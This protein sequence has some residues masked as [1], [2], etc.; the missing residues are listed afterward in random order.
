MDLCVVNGHRNVF[1]GRF[2]DFRGPVCV[3]GLVTLFSFL[4]ELLE[5]RKRDKVLNVRQLCVV[6]VRFRCLSKRKLGRDSSLT[7]RGPINSVPQILDPS[8]HPIEVAIPLNE[9]KHTT[10]PTMANALSYQAMVNL[11]HKTDDEHFDRQLDYPAL[12]QT[13][14][15]G[16]EHTFATLVARL[17]KPGVEDG[18]GGRPKGGKSRTA[19]PMNS[20]L[21]AALKA[22][23]SVSPT[24]MASPATASP[25]RSPLGAVAEARSANSAAA[26][27]LQGWGAEG[28]NK[29]AV[30]RSRGDSDP[31]AMSRMDRMTDSPTASPLGALRSGTAGKAP[32]SAA[33]AA[34]VMYMKGW[35]AEGASSQTKAARSPTAALSARSPT[36]ALSPKSAGGKPSAAALAHAM[37]YN[38]GWGQ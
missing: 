28:Q 16:D 19:S 35:G 27:Y 38:K 4:L 2:R 24:R 7:T 33:N 5:G 18:Y 20:P 36:A 22:R 10:V 29:S 15:Q 21:G 1:L 12:M 3:N 26:M 11:V 34:A 30:A 13:L 8:D 31:A 17:P 32:S 37:Q 9:T 14:G 23:A 25:A 6:K